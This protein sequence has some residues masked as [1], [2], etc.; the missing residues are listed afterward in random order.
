MFL[1]IA[2]YIISIRWNDFLLVPS[3]LM[4]FCTLWIA[5]RQWDQFG[6]TGPFLW[7]VIVVPYNKQF[8]VAGSRMPH[9]T[10]LLLNL[11]N[12]VKYQICMIFPMSLRYKPLK[13]SLELSPILIACSFLL[14]NWVSGLIFLKIHP[15]CC[16]HQGLG[17][18]LLR[19][20][21]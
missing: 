7:N 21:L 13:N 4:P 15:V 17:L 14:I 10:V 8:T 9:S 3:P 6:V 18:G 11:P 2:G 5:S 12:Y 19:I 1:Y 20:L 16:C